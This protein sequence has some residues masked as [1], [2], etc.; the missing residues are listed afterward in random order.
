MDTIEG[1]TYPRFRWLAMVTMSLGVIA[2]G[3][4]MTSPAPLIGEV[5]KYLNRDL[6][7]VTFTVMGL[8]TATVCLGG[9]IGGA[10][11]DQFGIVR[12][13]LISGVLLSLSTILMPVAGPN[14]P[15]I[16][17]LRLIGGFGTGPII[18]T[19]SRL[20]AEW[21]R[22]E[23]RGLITG[24]QGMSRALGVLV[25]LG[26]APVVFE[27]VKSW[28]ITMAWM[29]VPAVSFLV[30]AILMACGP[31]AP[32]LIVEEHEHRH[33]G[34]RDFKT[35][36][37]DPVIYLCVVYVFLFNWIV[38]GANNL[39]PGYF[40]VLPPV[41]VGWGPTTAGR[42]MMIFQLVFMVGSL[43]SGWLHDSVY[44]RDTRLQIMLAFVFAGLYFFL[45]FPK[46]IGRGPN[47]VL[48]LIMAASAF[49]MGQGIATIMAF[50]AK[51]YPEHITGKVGGMAMGLGLI[52]GVIGVAF[53]SKAL[54]QTHR[55]QLPILIVSAVA[56]PGFFA[57]FALKKPKSFQSL[58]HRQHI[59]GRGAIH[60]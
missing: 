21:F 45:K 55:Y 20:A 38:Q 5:A 39:T 37:K 29:S 26:M 31:K 3:V 44:K 30:F 19:I 27:A 25:G 23:E 51:N 8:W 47:F 33:A 53:G 40:A 7:L 46:V 12:V 59:E 1:A 54:A 50:I 34:Q 43:V 56:V 41:G 57:A 35:A 28:P 2:E 18:T 22:P 17:V 49:F 6:G 10:A 36:L 24:I 15:A 13:Y 4:I 11:V 16:V 42:I 58:E 52:G 14:L 9:L 60:A 32:E 48:L